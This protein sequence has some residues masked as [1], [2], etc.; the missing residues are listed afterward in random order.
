MKRSLSLMTATLLASGFVL[1]ACS[2]QEIPAGQDDGLSKDDGGGDATDG[3]NS[4]GGPPTQLQWYSTCGYPVCFVGD[5]GPEDAGVCPT[6]GTPCTDKGA[7]CGAPDAQNCGVTYV[8]DDHDPKGMTCPISTRKYK[9][10]IQ[11][12]DDAQLQALHDQ[13]LHMK[14]ATYNYKSQVADPDPTHL[15]FIIEDQP[16]QS[17]A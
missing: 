6:E 16:A 1:A 3:G 10:G 8:C 14:L 15:G 11:Y 4:D 5:A 7:T 13:T 2:G 12:V 9:D 17:L